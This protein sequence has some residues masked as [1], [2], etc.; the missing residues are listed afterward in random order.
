M[1]SAILK[2]LKLLLYQQSFISFSCNSFD[3]EEH[4]PILATDCKIEIFVVRRHESTLYCKVP[5]NA[6][7]TPII[8]DASQIKQKN[9]HMI[10][11]HIL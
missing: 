7:G 1:N 10:F 4:H 6:H 5:F 2:N 9:A 3:V 8:H 11:R